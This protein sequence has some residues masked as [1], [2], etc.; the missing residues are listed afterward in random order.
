MGI[1]YNFI[2]QVKIKKINL[3]VFFFYLFFSFY[4]SP[5]S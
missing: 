2:I 3:I 5:I 1:I 4:I